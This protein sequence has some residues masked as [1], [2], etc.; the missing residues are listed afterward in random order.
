MIS[1]SRDPREP[2]FSAQSTHK[3]PENHTLEHII[4]FKTPNPEIHFGP[5]NGSN[6][7]FGQGWAKTYGLGFGL[8]VW[9]SGFGFGVSGFGFSGATTAKSHSKVGGKT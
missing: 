8:R 6:G 4:S 5:S 3:Y 1:I 9:G 2:T 7:G